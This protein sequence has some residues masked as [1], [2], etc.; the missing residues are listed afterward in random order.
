MKK[1]TMMSIFLL[2]SVNGQA[3]PASLE[4][5]ELDGANGFIINGTSHQS[6]TGWS[7]KSAGDINGD[8]L[9]DLVFGA[10][11]VS[12][13]YVKYGQANASFASLTVD[14][15]TG[16]QGFMMFNS[17]VND[18]TLGWSVDGV[19]DVNGDGVDDL[20]IGDPNFDV[21]GS[22]GVGKV[23]VLYGQAMGFP[24]VVDLASLN[25]NNGFA[26]IGEESNNDGFGRLGIDL[27]AAGDLNDDGVDDLVVAAPYMDEDA[28]NT[29]SVYVLYGQNTGFPATINLSTL[30]VSQG[31]KMVG[32]TSGMILGRYVQ[33]LGD[34]N[35][36]HISD[37]GI[38]TDDS[39]ANGNPGLAFVLFGNALGFP[40]EVD[41][42]ALDG[43]NGFIIYGTDAGRERTIVANAGDFNGDGINDVSIGSMNDGDFSSASANM[44][45]MY[46]HNGEFAPSLSVN[47]LEG[48][49]GFAVI[50]TAPE[51]IKLGPK[52][53]TVG[54]FNGDGVDDWF[55]STFSD[56]DALLGYLI[57]GGLT[58]EPASISLDDLSGQNGYLVRASPF[59]STFVTQV[60]VAAM[61]DF[62][63]DGVNDFA[64]GN[65][66][67]ETNGSVTGAV[68]VVYGR[69]RPDLIFA[70]GFDQ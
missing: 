14:D 59:N 37:L 49:N 21:D 61:Q 55:I 52:A 62:N 6:W 40:L 30:T 44:Y 47:D 32:S 9:T 63:G 56:S 1:I 58:G 53:G 26:I 15:L 50:N 3:S 2:M 11:G 17:E 27:S 12:R 46:G 20:M 65:Q 60:P 70:D 4:L 66:F 8:G 7:V 51:L 18:N 13:A 10:D 28:F 22:P 67:N 68:F 34:V 36:D 57:F 54:D 29:G 45:L 35:G 23:F 24:D 38:S 39:A 5:S 69:S 48:S 42:S 64:I 41:L 31:F 19:G 43:T 16:N 33:D 25:G